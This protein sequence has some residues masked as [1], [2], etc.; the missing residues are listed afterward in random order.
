[1]RR[2]RAASSATSRVVLSVEDAA[3]VDLCSGETRRNKRIR[4]LDAGRFERGRRSRAKRVGLFVLFVRIG[5]F[6]SRVQI[7][8]A[9]VKAGL[10][11]S[12][13]LASAVRRR[14]VDTNATNARSKGRARS[15]G[16][17]SEAWIQA[18]RARRRFALDRAVFA[19]IWT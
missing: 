17:R 1:V 12:R 10:F 15:A 4:G 13:R 8:I 6:A 18:V 7:R 3:R 9:I 5:L 2:G 14:N 11:A 16:E 19:E